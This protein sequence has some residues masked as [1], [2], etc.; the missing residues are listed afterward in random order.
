MSLASYARTKQAPL[1]RASPNPL[2][3]V[4]NSVV[5][6]AG[7]DAR[8]DVIGCEVYAGGATTRVHDFSFDL[9]S[10]LSLISPFVST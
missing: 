6:S 1:Y 3:I 2:E 8:R 7:N 5:V 9:D 10:Q 4:P